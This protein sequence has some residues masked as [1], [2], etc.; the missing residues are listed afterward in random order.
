[1]ENLRAIGKA[2]DA[3]KADHKGELPN[4]LSDLYP[5]YLQ[6]TNLLLCPADKDKGVPAAQK[7][8]NDPKMSCS[9]N[10]QFSPANCPDITVFDTNPPKE[11][12]Y[13]EAKTRQL[14]YFGGMTPV[15]RC[16]HHGEQWIN[17][18]C[19]GK[20]YV[21]PQNWGEMPEAVKA[22]LSSFQSAVKKNP[23]G[24]EKELSV[25]KMYEYF[26]SLMRLSDLL[27]FLEK[28]PNLS[29]DALKIMSDIYQ[30][31]GEI[32]KEMASL[33]RLLRLQGL[34][35]LL[36]PDNTE[37]RLRLAELY[38][39]TKRYQS[40]R[41]QCQQ[42]IRTDPDNSRANALL[43]EL[44]A[45]ADGH[46]IQ[47]RL[48]KTRAKDPELHYLAKLEEMLLASKEDAR[49][50]V[51]KMQDIAQESFGEPSSVT[52]LAH[53]YGNLGKSFSNARGQLR[54]YNS[55]DGLIDNFVHSFAQDA[56]GILWRAS[57]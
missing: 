44:D 33:K 57:I 16:S 42:I 3:Y 1:M 53:L 10:Y 24:W 25:G 28:V 40:A 31:H 11:M 19:D 14:K 17:L 2:T 51:R 8:P 38:A 48:S 46:R 36:A 23:D 47:E 32:D 43:L 54:T 55:S 15:V 45:V 52:R 9:Y 39:M 37:H 18:S 29:A 35:P 21:S 27:A 30:L 5:K 4:W 41:E 34:R 6:D 12:T 20:V 56:R 13:K 49:S 50:R 26:S 22:V 7:E